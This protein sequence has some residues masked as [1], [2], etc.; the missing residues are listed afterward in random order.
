METRAGSPCIIIRA[1]ASTGIGTG[2]VMRCLTLAEELRQRG[3]NIHFLCRAHPGHMGEV[4]RARGFALTLLPPP[5][6]LFDADDY[7]TWLGAPAGEDARQTMEALQGMEVAWLIVD[8][9]AIDEHWE[10]LLRPH[11]AKILVIDDLANRHHDCDLLLDQNYGRKDTDYRPLVGGNTMALTGPHYALLRPEYREHRPAS[12]KANGVRNK[13]VLVYFG[14]AD[15]YNLTGQVLLIL[16]QPEFAHY[17]LDVVASEN[18]PYRKELEA[19]AARLSSVTLH[20][21]RPHLADLMAEADFAIGAAGATTWERMCLGLPSLVFALAANQQPACRAMAENGLVY[22]LGATEEFDSSLLRQVLYKVEEQTA[23]SSHLQ[24]NLMGIVDGYGVKRIGECVI[25]SLLESLHLR[26]AQASDVDLYFRWVN[27][28][29]VRAS[30]LNSGSIKW[31][32]HA[33]WFA[34]KRED[35]NAFLFVL[36]SHGLPIG[37][38]RFDVR[39]G[40]AEIDY[41][42]DRIVRGRGL[43]KYLLRRGQD[44]L[45]KSVSIKEFRAIVKRENVASVKVFEGLGYWEVAGEVNVREFRLARTEFESA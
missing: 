40:V 39:E 35:I 4:I 26:L 44:V 13:R 21:T 36:E 31:A 17:H 16:T 22:Y 5:V 33:V 41:S 28:P 14:G 29:A 42:L 23:Q 27:D 32:D 18:H 24:K 1:D 8:H 19:M 45:V 2:H 6:M 10:Q 12:P 30:A 9:Y 15:I 11:T 25:P 34:R 37:Q 43:A 38:V 20:G 3:A 7:A